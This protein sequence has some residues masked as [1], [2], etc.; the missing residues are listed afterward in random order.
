[1]RDGLTAHAVSP[2]QHGGSPVREDTPAAEIGAINRGFY[3]IAGHIAGPKVDAIR[4]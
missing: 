2:S 1:M 4:H 3:I